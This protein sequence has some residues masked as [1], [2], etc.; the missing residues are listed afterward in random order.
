MQRTAYFFH[1]E[2]KEFDPIYINGKEL[3]IAQSVKL[4]G[5]II[6]HNLSW[7][8]HLMDTVKTAAMQALAFFSIVEKSKFT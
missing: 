1:K 6:S 8:A 5:V 2:C 3:E 7:N 4:L